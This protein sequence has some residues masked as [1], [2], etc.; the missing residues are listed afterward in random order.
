MK[1]KITVWFFTTVVWT[2]VALMVDSIN[3]YKVPWFKFVLQFTSGLCLSYHVLCWD[4]WRTGLSLQSCFD[5]LGKHF[6][7]W[8]N[9]KDVFSETS[10]T[11]QLQIFGFI[12]CHQ[13]CLFRNGSNLRER[14]CIYYYYCSFSQ[15]MY[16]TVM[17]NISFVLQCTTVSEHLCFS[18]SICLKMSIFCQSVVVLKKNLYTSKTSQM[19]I[20]A[21]L[22]VPYAYAAHTL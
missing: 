3:I 15:W 2:N 12:V 18:P 19:K 6:R 22:S 8:R 10:K 1:H 9:Q 13:K 16:C 21:S 11:R 4:V 5:F 20:T 14:L 7:I 17:W